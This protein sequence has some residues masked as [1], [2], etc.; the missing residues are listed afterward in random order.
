MT[1]T[2]YNN[3][4]TVLET[5]TIAQGTARA[6]QFTANKSIYPQGQQIQFETTTYA[7][8]RNRMDFAISPC[9]GVFESSQ[10]RCS[11]TKIKVTSILTGFNPS[12]VTKC[13]LEDGKQ[14]YLNIRPSQG[15]IDVAKVVG[16][17]RL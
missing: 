6:F 2:H 12:D 9:P 7:G 8:G 1:W 3:P 13:I 16:S 15:Y 4:G 14:Y 5:K 10:K 11:F 17:Q